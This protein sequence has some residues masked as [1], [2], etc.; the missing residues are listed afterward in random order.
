MTVKWKGYIRCENGAKN[1]VPKTKD[2]ERRL[3]QIVKSLQNRKEPIF[4]PPYEPSS[5]AM[6]IS[7][8]EEEFDDFEVIGDHPF[9]EIERDQRSPY[10]LKK[11]ATA[12]QK[13]S[14]D[15]N[16]TPQR[17]QTKEKDANM[18]SQVDS[19]RTSQNETMTSQNHQIDE[20]SNF[21]SNNLYSRLQN[22]SLN[23]PA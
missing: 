4:A 19:I 12:N 2:K 21:A 14:E 11:L 20:E 5:T 6:Q 22:I 10:F 8:S 9:K 1:E 17:L 16:S 15:P 18:T 7:H 23:L 3:D 13:Y